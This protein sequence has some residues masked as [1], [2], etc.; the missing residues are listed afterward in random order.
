MTQTLE[1]KIISTSSDLMNETLG[2]AIADG[3]VPC[4]GVSAVRSGLEVWLYQTMTRVVPKR[5][6]STGP[7]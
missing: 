4:G 3:W 7:R 5:E 6:P 2:S 1:A